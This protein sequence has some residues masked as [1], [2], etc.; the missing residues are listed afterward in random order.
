LPNGE[1]SSNSDSDLSE[2]DIVVIK[3]AGVTGGALTGTS[4]FDALIGNRGNDVFKASG[5]FDYYEGR[6][7][8]DRVDGGS[9]SFEFFGGAGTDTAIVDAGDWTIRF[10]THSGRTFLGA[11]N[12]ET[13]Q[14]VSLTDVENFRIGNVNHRI[15]IAPE[16]G[17]TLT[18]TTRAD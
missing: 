2:G 5:G 3:I 6:F 7:G 13:G 8:D 4:L 14:Q 10:Q 11:Y 9:Y 16:S 12:L 17:G 15:M 1:Y 18:G